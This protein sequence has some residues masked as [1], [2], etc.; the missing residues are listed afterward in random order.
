MGKERLSWRRTISLFR[1]Y[2]NDKKGYIIIKVNQ[3]HTYTQAH[4]YVH[5]VI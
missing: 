4:T 5:T 2:I 3:T 1:Y